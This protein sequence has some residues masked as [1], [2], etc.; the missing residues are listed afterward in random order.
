VSEAIAQVTRVAA[1]ALALDADERILLCRMAP[2]QP[3]A[4]KWTLPGGGLDFGEDPEAGLLRELAEEA[5]LSGEVRGIAGVTSRVV[6][7][8]RAGTDVEL[9]ALGICYLV[10]V[11][12][13]ALRDETD[14]STDTCA[15]IPVREVHDVPHTHLVASGLGFLGRHRG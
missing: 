10:T 5:G 2:G 3:G 9:H 15:W 4:G 8:R 1:Y 6:R 7:A 13:G 12:G 14:G 11:T